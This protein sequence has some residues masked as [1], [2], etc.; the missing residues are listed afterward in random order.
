MSPRSSTLSRRPR[1]L[2]LAAALLAAALP[3]G[4]QQVVVAAI[5]KLKAEGFQRSQVMEVAS[6]LT[7][8][9]GPRLTNSPQAR[10]AGDWVVETLQG[11][12]MQNVAL[13]WFPFGRGWH[14]ERTVAHVV[15][16]TPYP[17]IA[18]PGAWTVGTDGPVVGEVVVL[19]LPDNASDADYARLRGTLAT[20]NLLTL[21]GRSRRWLGASVGHLA[22][23]EMTSVGPM[24]RYASAVRRVTGGD[25][26]AEFYDVHVVA[27][28]HHQ[29]VA[30][31]AMV[32]PFVAD[33]P[34]L[35]SDV[36]FGARALTLVETRFTAHLLDRWA[37]NSTSL[38]RPVIRIRRTH[39]A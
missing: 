12:G 38:R 29:H 22:L 23:F 7:D 32:V 19:D 30:L 28:E 6:W 10:A 33:E 21:F 14:N 2:P 1:A 34:A 27:D 18:I 24:A 25:E 31:E 8:V 17:V 36:L 26:G 11:W 20:V 15:S 3:A 4:A 5:E 16:P 37:T 35:A 9:H 39:A 13:E